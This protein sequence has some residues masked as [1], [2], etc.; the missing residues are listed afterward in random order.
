MNK[1]N[2]CFTVGLVL[3]FVVSFFHGT[4]QL[5]DVGLLIGLLIASFIVGIA[6][7]QPS[8]PESN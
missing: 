4:M 7:T 1:T 8:T 5:S 3:T 2:I 6:V